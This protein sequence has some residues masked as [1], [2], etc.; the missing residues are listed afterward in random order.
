MEPLKLITAFSILAAPAPLPDHP[1]IKQYLPV[2]VS[3]VSE[4]WS[5]CPIPSA[6]AGQVEQETCPSLK[7]KMCWSPYAELKTSREYGFGLGQITLTKSFDNFAEA[8]KL[9]S[10]LAGWKWENRWNAE[11]QLRTLV[12]TDK[13]NYE[14]FQTAYS[15][16]DRMAFALAG[17]NGGVAGVLSDRRVCLATAGCNPERWF[18][19]VEHT[20]KKSR[21]A[22][23]GYGKS[24]FQI[25]REY[26]STILNLRRH[27]YSH[28]FRGE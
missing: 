3:E 22:A 20:S 9:D 23:S 27:R 14:K 15:E 18:G 5:S 28:A 4:R 8:R 13:A 19:N 24:F 7:S 26:V 2:L 17:Y 21:V 10:S 16:F 1:N 25:N 6:L 12:L 11:F